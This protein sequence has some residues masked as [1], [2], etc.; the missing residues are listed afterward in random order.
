MDKENFFISLVESPFLG[1]DAAVVGSTLYSCD[2]FC[3]GAH[4]KREWMSMRQIG[5]K[6][7]LVNLSDVVAMNAE[8]VYALV[9]VTLP[10][11]ISPKEMF[12]L[13]EGL[14]SAAEEYGCAIIGGDTVGGDLVH[15]SIT[16]I[17]KST[18]PLMRTGMKEGDLLA[19][20]GELGESRRALESLMRGEKIS[21]DSR[22]YEPVLRK[23]FIKEAR[24]YI[25]CGMDISDGLYCDLGKML[26]MNEYG[27]AISKSID[28]FEAESGEEY[29]MLFAFDESHISQLE[30]ISAR[31]STPVNIFG[32]VLADGTVPP[33]VDHHFS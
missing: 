33:C 10:R 9:G 2:I 14:T 18:E 4:F 17:S 27:C 3:E 31:T 19:Y 28:R 29:E 30:E 13:S 20:T 15:I 26:N 32:R 7:M 24:R 11:D 23:E 6:A 21:P 12:E 16:I 8:P 25:S 1:D 5:R 22:F